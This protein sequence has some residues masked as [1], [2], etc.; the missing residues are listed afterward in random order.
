[1]KINWRRLRATLKRDEGYDLNRHEV[2]GIDH[3][4]YGINL[5]QELPDELLEYLGVEDEDDIQT[6]THDQAD[7][8]LLQYVAIAT[9]DC[10]QIY[11]DAWD[12]LSG[13]RQEVLINLSF[14]LGMPRLKA[15]RKMNK[16]IRESEWAE[17]AAQMID[18]KAARQTGDRYPRLAAAFENDDAKYLELDGDFSGGITEESVSENV[19][20]GYGDEQLIRELER[21]LAAI[22]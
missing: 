17:A 10:E 21:R 2:D 3:I 13:L 6:I 5:E 14:N 19:L 9:S 8:L 18:S 12:G 4:G 15:F 7:Y 20:A 11:G 16:A 1:M 22:R